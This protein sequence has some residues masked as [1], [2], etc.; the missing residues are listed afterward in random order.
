MIT[1]VPQPS[2]SGTRIVTEVVSGP[3][4]IGSRPSCSVTHP[5]AVPKISEAAE[6]TIRASPI[7]SSVPTSLSIC[8][9]GFITKGP[10]CIMLRI[11]SRMPLIQPRDVNTVTTAAIPAA[12]PRL[13][14]FSSA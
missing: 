6:L 11:P 5:A 8:R 13:V 14:G 3:A 7:S 12:Q 4:T 10:S 2:S 1:A 9:I